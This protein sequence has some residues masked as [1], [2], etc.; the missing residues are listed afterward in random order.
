[1]ENKICSSCGSTKFHEATDYIPLKPTKG[2]FQ[3]AHKIFSFCM[4]CGI[5]DS[6]RIE[7][8]EIFQNEY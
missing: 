4:D 6:I 1:M 8:T 7:N 2:S 5:V 3:G